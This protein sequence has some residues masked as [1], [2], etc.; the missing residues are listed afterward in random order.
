MKIVAYSDPEY[1]HT[2]GN[3]DV[4]FNPENIK[5]NKEQQFST[6]NSTNGSSAQT[7]AYKG[8]GSSNFEVKLFFDGTG[9][10]SAEPVEDQINKLK[11]LAYDFNGDIHEPNYL[12][13]YWGSQS[14]FEGRLK[15][16]NVNH[17]LLD[18]D[19]SPMRSEL[20]L[21]LVA[22]VSAKKK[23]L[24]EK[25]NSSDLTH[26]R[27]VKDGDTLP[28]MCYRIY[29]DSKYYIRV[30]QENNLVNFRDLKPGDQIA[31]PPVN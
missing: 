17:T 22:S 4:L 2:V 7:V 5:D 15:S 9:I 31:F 23:G 10:I 26:L 29:G 19:G 28:L 3:Y 25:K 20:S 13:I 6:S 14:L 18:L 12:R 27:T 30:A 16:W 1:A 21:R 8:V 24:V 11:K